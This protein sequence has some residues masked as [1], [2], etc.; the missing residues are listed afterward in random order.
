[1]PREREGFREQLARLDERYPGREMLTI[2]EAAE[3]VD[4]GRRFITEI[5][6]FPLLRVGCT[7]KGSRG[8]YRVPKVGLARW[9]CG[10]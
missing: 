8:K 2:D 9:M 5:D 10:A 4:I 1:M 7:K 6:G 3:L